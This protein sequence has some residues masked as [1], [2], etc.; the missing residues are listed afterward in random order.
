MTS[1][2][3]SSEYESSSE[4]TESSVSLS[5]VKRS[6]P[7]KSVK[8]AKKGKSHK[9]K[10]AK[11]SKHA[12]TAKTKKSKRKKEKTS[13]KEHT[14]DLSGDGSRKAKPTDWGG[15][16]SWSAWTSSNWGQYGSS[17][18][19]GWK[20]GE[21]DAVD[22]RGVPVPGKDG[23]RSRVGQSLRRRHRSS[24][25]VLAGGMTVN[26]AGGQILPR[27]HG[28]TIGRSPGKIMR[29]MSG[30]CSA[31]QGL[32]TRGSCQFF[33]PLTRMKLQS[34]QMRLLPPFRLPGACSKLCFVL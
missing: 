10:K 19:R 18:S 1:S 13:R 7:R 15:D 34:L 25:S 24:P 17:G 16:A 21:H 30:E 2:T 26:V 32:A 28:R 22:S 11:S 12:K 4:E 20:S 6:K 23:S 27:T 8:K 9:A 5:P 14:T 3:N 29:M 33:T 31:R